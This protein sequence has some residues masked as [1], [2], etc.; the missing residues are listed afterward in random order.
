MSDEIIS[1]EDPE[2]I[3]DSIKGST[4]DRLFN[5]LLI[6]ERRL[7]V[8]IEDVRAIQAIICAIQCELGRRR[9][10]DIKA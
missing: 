7:L 4:S 6:S 9:I 3:L 5:M 8:A 1:T 2:S 10:V